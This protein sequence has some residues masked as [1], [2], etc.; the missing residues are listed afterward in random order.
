MISSSPSGVSLT[1]E[2][3]GRARPALPLA[4]L[5]ERYDSAVT[6]PKTAS[7]P[8]WQQQA[9]DAALTAAA[10]RLGTAQDQHWKTLHTQAAL[11]FVVPILAIGLTA[12]CCAAPAVYL[13]E[14]RE[15]T[16]YFASGGLLVLA[17][18]YWAYRATAPKRRVGVV[19]FQHGLVH[20]DAHQTR[21]I[22]W[23]EVAR[24]WQRITKYYDQSLQ[25]SKTKR[26]KY[27][28]TLE[29]VT[30]GSVHINDQFTDIAGLTNRIVAEVTQR[31]L[32]EAVRLIQQG[33]TLRFGPFGIGPH[34]IDNGQET[35]PWSQVRDLK[36]LDGELRVKKDG[37]W[38]PWSRQNVGGIP[39][40]FVFFAIAKKLESSGRTSTET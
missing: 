36:V 12:L 4:S 28:V 22:P 19:V 29:S 39:N 38:R 6:G 5:I 37:R 17:V 14:A 16:P 15:A 13:S 30:A 1:H 34:G 31:Q 32:P 35:L 7:P 2:R 26:T 21:V 8:T 3:R 11:L 10:G 24:V 27:E 9:V 23:S 18:G 33:Q 20:V 25:E 40:F